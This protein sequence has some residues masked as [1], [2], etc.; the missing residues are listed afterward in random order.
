MRNIGAVAALLVMLAFIGCGTSPAAVPDTGPGTDSGTPGSDS[1]VPHAPSTFQV[2][3]D[4]TAGSFSVLAHR[5]WAPNGVDRFYELVQAHYYDDTRIFRVLTGFVAQFG[6]NG[7]PAV[8]A[9]YTH[10]TIP[11]DPVLGHNTRGT[12]SYAMAGTDRG[13]R[14][15]QLFVN[16]ADNSAG[17]DA[18]GFAPI[19][20]VTSGMNVVDMFYAGYM[21]MPMQRNIQQTGN[22]YLDTTFPMLTHITS[23]HVLP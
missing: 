14:T 21:D 3:F 13:S 17:L 10:A 22:S 19:A 4:T 6:L 2:Q 20:E 1:G 11:A 7:D 8:T 5:D 16:L 9:M 18:M 15:T 12:I 23:A